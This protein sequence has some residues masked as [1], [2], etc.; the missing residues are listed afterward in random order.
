MSRP[1]A[2]NFFETTADDSDDARYGWRGKDFI[3]P[4]MR[5]LRYR[6]VTIGRFIQLVARCDNGCDDETNPLLIDEHTQVLDLLSYKS[7]SKQQI[8]IIREAARSASQAVLFD[9]DRAGKECVGSSVDRRLACQLRGQRF[10]AEYSTGVHFEEYLMDIR[11]LF[12]AINYALQNRKPIR[13]DCTTGGGELTIAHRHVFDI[14]PIHI[15]AVFHRDFKLGEIQLTRGYGSLR[16][17]NRIMLLNHWDKLDVPNLF[18]DKGISAKR[19]LESLK[20][21]KIETVAFHSEE[22][23]VYEDCYHTAVC[24]LYWAFVWL[25]KQ[26]VDSRSPTVTFNKDTFRAMRHPNEPMRDA[27]MRSLEAFVA[28]LDSADADVGGAGTSV[29]DAMIHHRELLTVSRCE[30]VVDIPPEAATVTTQY[31]AGSVTNN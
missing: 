27:V 31:L 14:D 13:F 29:V 5:D 21:L 22:P 23:P 8:E 7:L 4:H 26:C 20:H 18:F 25:A 3:E 16:D 12:T 2:L 11:Y 1:A 9:T 30:A 6:D 28:S 19:L 10:N 15:R 24:D 17:Y